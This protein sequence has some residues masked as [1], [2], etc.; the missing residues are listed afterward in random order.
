MAY[1]PYSPLLFLHLIFLH[2]CS[3]LTISN[4]ANNHHPVFLFFHKARFS[5][6]AARLLT[7]RGS[8]LD[9]SLNAF[10][11]LRTD[12]NIISG[13]R[14]R[15]MN[16]AQIVVSLTSIS[17]TLPIPVNSCFISYLINQDTLHQCS[18]KPRMAHVAN[19]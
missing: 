9:F 10:R 6:D 11:E 13:A 7:R 8:R 15:L 19:S 5:A 14:V 4:I 2:N 17:L 18:T 12:C 3:Y 16:S 1:G